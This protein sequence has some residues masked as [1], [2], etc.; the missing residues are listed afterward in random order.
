MRRWF[1]LHLNILERSLLIVER[2][3]SA[4]GNERNILKWFQAVRGGHRIKLDSGTGPV[5]VNPDRIVLLLCFARPDPRKW[6]ESDF[7]KTARFCTMLAELVERD[8]R[9]HTPQFK[10]HIET[11]SYAVTDWVACGRDFASSCRQ[12]M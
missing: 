4:P 2:E 6:S 3:G 12:W 9:E 10:V 5:A 1:T 7:M 11:R 8:L